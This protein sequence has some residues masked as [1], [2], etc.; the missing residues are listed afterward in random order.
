MATASL[1]VNSD[2]GS[3][4]RVGGEGWNVAADELNPLPEYAVDHGTR[5]RGRESLGSGPVT[6]RRQAKHLRCAV[7]VP[8]SRSAPLPPPTAGIYLRGQRTGLEAGRVRC[9]PTSRRRSGTPA[10]RSCRI[11]CGAGTA[12]DLRRHARESIRVL[13]RL[14]GRSTQRSYCCLRSSE[15]TVFRFQNHRARANGIDAHAVPPE[16]PGQRFG[17]S[18]RARPSRGHVGL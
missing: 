1:A 17:Q 14:G 18:R 2:N 4:T 16:F 9:Y 13:Q 7:R 12:P 15:D 6:G 5:S 10:R 11:R 3:S 8:Y